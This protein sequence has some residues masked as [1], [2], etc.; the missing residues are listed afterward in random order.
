MPA[1]AGPAARDA[2]EAPPARLSGWPGLGFD[3]VPGTP[4]LVEALAGR[5]AAVSEALREVRGLVEPLRADP[6]GWTGRAADA[7]AA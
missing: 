7:F 1:D 4:E 2:P 5:L 6:D 3:P